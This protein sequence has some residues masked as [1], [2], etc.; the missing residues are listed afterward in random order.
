MRQ[1]RLLKAGRDS[2]EPKLDFLGKSHSSTESRPA[3]LEFS[4]AA[5][6]VRPWVVGR[7]LRARR[8]GQRT[9]RPTFSPSVTDALRV[10]DKTLLLVGATRRDARTP[11]RGVTTMCMNNSVLHPA[12]RAADFSLAKPLPAMQSQA[13]NCQ[14]MVR[15]IIPIRSPWPSLHPRFNQTRH[16]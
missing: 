1:R 8:G 15:R 16:L 2:V 11:R 14:T 6:M 13:K 12:A 5:V 10:W 4:R 3:A 9:T 7:A